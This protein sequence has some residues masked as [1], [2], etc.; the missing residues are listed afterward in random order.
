MYQK[1]LYEQYWIRDNGAITD[2]VLHLAY[3]PD[4]PRKKAAPKHPDNVRA[5]YEG[6]SATIDWMVGE[7]GSYG[8]ALVVYGQPG[9]GK[10]RFLRIERARLF[11]EG[12]PCIVTTTERSTFDLYCDAGA[13]FDI[14]LRELEALD[15]LIPTIA[16]VDAAEGANGG[17]DLQHAFVN[18][19][20]AD[21]VVVFAASPRCLSSLVHV[22]LLSGLPDAPDV[23]VLDAQA[24]EDLAKLRNE[25]RIKENDRRNGFYQFFADV[26]TPDVARP[27]LQY[28]RSIL[29]PASAPLE[30]LALVHGIIH[31]VYSARTMELC[32]ALAV[33]ADGSTLSIPRLS[34]VS[35]VLPLVRTTANIDEDDLKTT[36]AVAKFDYEGLSEQKPTFP[37]D[38]SFASTDSTLPRLRSGIYFPQVGFPALD[39]VAIFYHEDELLVVA[40]QMTMSM[41][42]DVNINGILSLYTALGRFAFKAKFYFAFVAPTEETGRALVKHSRP[43][44]PANSLVS[45]TRSSS[46]DATKPFTWSRAFT[47]ADPKKP[48]QHV[49]ATDD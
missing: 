22:N 7:R 21:V 36:E 23:P 3:A 14:R 10:S 42:H 28:P 29:V 18:D 30:R 6:I 34:R 26:S 12:R 37:L 24:A 16:L 1:S 46:S 38:E 8:A 41:R 20:I 19:F 49:E 44:L 2:G 4:S 45:S 27:S 9:C 35:I 31:E 17:T 48:V 25:I 39:A 40:L 47:V 11:E 33:L 5:E 32:G 43:A 15:L 13:F